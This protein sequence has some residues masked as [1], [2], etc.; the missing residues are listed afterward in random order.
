MK[1]KLLLVLAALAGPALGLAADV[2]M[3]GDDTLGTTSFNTAGKWSPAGA[4]SAGNNYFSGDWVLRTPPNGSSYAF[5]GDALTINNTGVYSKGLLYKGTGATGIVTVANLILSGGRIS[6]AN[7]IGDVLNLAG[8]ISL[9]NTGEVYAKQGNIN[10]LA[11]LSGSGQ[12]AIPQTDSATE[13][14]RYVSL[15]GNNAGFTG[16]LIVA[17]R[18]RANSATS[19][20]GSLATFTPDAV[21]L[22]NA[23]N[24]NGA[25]LTV[26]NS[27]TFNAANRGLTLGAAGAQIFVN[28]PDTNTVVNLTI[29][30]PIT[31]GNLIKRGGGALTL[32]GANSHAGVTMRAATAGSQLNLNNASA[33]GGGALTLTADAN[34]AILDNTSGATVSLNVSGA[35]QNWNNSFS[36]RGS[37]ILDMTALGSVTLGAQVIGSVSNSFLIVGSLNGAYGFTKAGAGTLAVDGGN[38]LSG[39][40]SVSE[41]TLTFSGA[42]DITSPVITVASNAFLAV[43]N[44]SDN[45]TPGLVLNSGQTLS[46]SGRVWGNVSDASGAIISPGTS[47]GTLSIAGNLTLDAGSSLNY[48]LANVTTTGGGVNDY[49]V[50]SGTLNVSGPTT[51]NLTYLNGLPAGSG[52]YTLISYGLFSGD[53]NNISVPPGFTINNNIAA[54]TIELLLNH[55]P[56]N[57]TWRGDGVSD[58]WD[59]D[60]TPNWIQ[61]G[62]PVTFFNGDTANFD[63]T[64]SN[65]PPIYVAAPVTA[66]AVNV[67]ATRDYDFTGSSITAATLSKNGSGT[68]ILENDNNYATGV[69]IGAGTL[70]VGAG[71]TGTLTT[72]NV[73]NNG[74]LVFNSAYAQTISGPV[75]GSGSISNLGPSGAV[76]LAGR[77]S[78]TTV[79]MAGAGSLRLNASNDYTGLTLVTSGT[80]FVGNS[81]ALGS[82]TV[83]TVVENGTLYVDPGQPLSIADEALTLNNGTLRRGGAQ[84]LWWS[85]PVSLA[86]AG[87]L[88]VDGGSTLHLTNATGISG[89]DVGLTLAGSGNGNI[90]GPITLGTG[91]LTVSGGTW[92]VA[93]VNNYS[94]KTFLNGGRLQIPALTAL[95]PIPGSATPDF[96]SFGGG[97][98]SLTNNQTFSS[99]LRGLTINSAGT[100]NVQDAAATV[101]VSGDLNGAGNFSKWGPGTLILSGANSYAGNIYLDGTSASANDGVTRLTANSAL[102]NMAVIP[103]TATLFQGNN[104]T[105]WSTLQLDGSG[106]G[107]TLA[108][109]WSMNCRNNDNPN[110]QNLAGNNVLSGTIHLNVGGNRVL[111]QADAGLLTLSGTLQYDGTLTGGRTWTFTGVGNTLVSGAILNSANGAPISL[112]KNGTG[113]LTLSAANSYGNTTTVNGGVLELTGS[114]TSTGGVLVAGGALAGTG[115]IN[116]NVTVITSAPSETI[117][118]LSVSGNFTLNGV[119]TV[120]VN[121]SGSA[122]DFTTVA[123][124]VTNVGVGAI[125]VNNLGTALQAGDTFTLFNKPVDHGAA[126]GVSGG[127]VLWTNR[128]AVDGSIAVVS[129][130]LPRPTLSSPTITGPTLNFSGSGGPALGAYQLVTSIDAS[131]PVD[132]W[133]VVSLGVF[134]VTGSLSASVA[135]PA[136][137]LQQFY[138]VRIPSP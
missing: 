75:S 79:T 68:L 102:A 123:G 100:I 62:S 54:K 2:A 52:K 129:T 122:R 11:N 49:L 87:A 55:T 89:P 106:G 136:S 70:Q 130:T 1:Q 127:G 30:N 80:L 94:G 103:G 107:I 114:L 83:G 77:V 3:T 14:N 58:V 17:G 112:A 93:A 19:L 5:A 124:V 86:G 92:N 33:L 32:A 134:D 8:N 88:D 69:S 95:G 131:L 67:N 24:A 34:P 133:T 128:L 82:T 60:I 9:V 137:T 78:G 63:D 18:I 84:A 50:V 7:G 29:A 31:G 72:T 85:T 20:G 99:G 15:F 12:L 101:T 74:A 116:D 109:D 96:V 125:L 46:G 104:N 56:A 121:R 35:G 76:T 135:M 38:Y 36:F 126:L 61:A 28:N 90:S 51:L 81:N 117:D 65:S 53:V 10:L 71:N 105:G 27:F 108:A 25:W 59:I 42:G 64:G 57:L 39:N 115:A 45:G 23:N 132:A 44:F 110:V 73:T 40:T 16:K 111:F 41:G 113:K 26:S 48:E 13:D 98:L 6:H 37:S 22:D 138:A 21:T 118:A 119:Y 66:A 4:P 91:A 97:V 120:D 43:D 47:A